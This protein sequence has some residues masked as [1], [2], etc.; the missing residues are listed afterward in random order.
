MMWNWEQNDWPNF[1]FG[2]AGF[3]APEK[4][5]LYRAG[6][7]LGAMTHIGN[8][9]R[10][11]LTIDIMSE[12]AV[13][14]SEIE[15]E[16]L[17]RESVQSSIRRQFG[18]ATDTLKARPAE[19]GIAEMMADLYHRTDGP[20]DAERLFTWHRQLMQGRHDLAAV[21]S[22]RTHAEPMQ[23][24]SGPLHRPKVHFQAPPSDQVPKEM[25]RFLDWFNRT[26]PDGPDRLSPVIRAGIA[27]LY[28]VSI[29]P[30]EDGNGR[31]A[32]A[33]SELALSQA[34]KRPTL[35]ALSRTIERHKN[36]YYDQL[37]ASNKTNRITDWLVYFAQ[38]VLD[39]QTQTHQYI[40]FLIEKTKL[41]DR[42]RDNIHPRQQ[43]C[44]LRMFR[45]GPDGFT[46][47]LSAR[48]YISITK[49]S[50]ATATRDLNELVDLGV[51]TK[52]GERRH[53]RYHL[54][55][56]LSTDSTSRW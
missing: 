18:L 45:E 23:V 25:I 41:L 49:V 46:G 7:L 36:T 26:A 5:F 34:L 28:F 15:G 48:N 37:E 38:T 30:F 56:S 44:L 39:A 3:E 55:I 2:A 32:R 52:T 42:V 31:I 14:T 11:Q 1:T 54:P 22:Y 12:E 19:R 16:I 40:V 20:L 8:D 29:H 33:I 27:H 13:K 53:T 10:Q 35:I 17:D 51:L 47:G 43:K 21:G 6:V 50:P 24:V 9:D 4:D